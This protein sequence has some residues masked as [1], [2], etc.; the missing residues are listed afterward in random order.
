MR[1]FMLDGRLSSAAKFV[2]QGAVFADIGTDHAH[3][4]IFL[5][6]TGVISRAVCSDINEGPLDKAREN[7]K[8]AGL[9]SKIDF[10]LTDGALAL[11][12]C[13]VSDVAIC[14]M[15]GELI[16]RIIEDAKWLHSSAVHLILQPMTR[17]AHLR[18]ALASLGFSISAE[19]Y[20]KADGKHYVCLLASYN[21]KPYEISDVEAEI[22]KFYKYFDND[23]LQIEYLEAKKRAFL[24]VAGGKRLGGTSTDF[25]E[26]L[27]LAIDERI[28]AIKGKEALL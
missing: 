18:R 7:A 15:G 21:G 16:A 3:L 12:E 13:G 17:V 27:I 20:S 2:R 23:S 10:Y 5:L 22:G 11:S 4:P 28:N 14:G 19:S 26:K 24:K 9:L 6:K 25:E 1:E 8:D